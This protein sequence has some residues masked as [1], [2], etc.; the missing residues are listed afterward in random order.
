MTLAVDPTSGAS[1]LAAYG[2]LAVLLVTFAEAGMLVVGFFLPGDSLLFP[3]GVLC[4]SAPGSHLGHGP[5]L[6][7]W[8]VLLAAAVGS[9]VGTQ[10]GFVIGQH[11]GRTLLAS[12]CS[13]RLKGVAAR[14]E[15]LLDRYGRRK[16]IVFGRFIP[17]V[18]TVLGPLAGALHVPTRTFTVWQVVGGLIWTQGTVLAG[19]LLGSSVP[20]VQNYLLP[21]V[22]LMV[23]LSL[24][25]LLFRR[26]RSGT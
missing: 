25:P 18:R 1:L 22:L 19:Y 12:G 21:L 7:L 26:R 10:V 16:A 9:L 6:S 23:A 5:Y 24:L 8:Q 20:G 11:G 4:A 15:D 3:A 14:A 17:M 2:A 13:R